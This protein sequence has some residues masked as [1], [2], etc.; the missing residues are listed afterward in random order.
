MSTGTVRIDPEG[1]YDDASLY[2]ALG[3]SA[4]ALARARREGRLRYTRQG[5]RLLY[6]GRWVI[7]WLTSDARLEAARGEQA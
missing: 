1:I 2:G 4:A 3:V 5:K 7:D 6:L